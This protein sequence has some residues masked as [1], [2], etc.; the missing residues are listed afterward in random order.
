[1]RRE[2]RPGKESVSTTSQVEGT[3]IMAQTDRSQRARGR[4]GTLLGVAL[5]LAGCS[6]DECISGPDCSG[7]DVT[8][9]ISGTVS[10]ASVGLASVT[11]AL[12][13]GPS[14]TTGS[15]GGYSFSDVAMGTHVVTVSHLPT[16]VSCPTPSR[17]VT[18]SS[19]AREATANF[20]CERT[21]VDPPGGAAY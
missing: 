16:G 13:G 5:L 4:L 20:N 10:V 8:G 3:L 7:D 18:L 6:G 2:G 14:A 11:V 21:A 19:S 12:S 1:M 15:D 17:S 9:T